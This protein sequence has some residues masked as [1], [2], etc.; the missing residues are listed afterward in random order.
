MSL[1]RQL[2][3]SVL[4]AE[5]QE[6]FEHESLYLRYTRPTTPAP[7][8][9]KPPWV[10]EQER[11][12]AQESTERRLMQ[13]EED[14]MWQLMASEDAWMLSCSA[15]AREIRR[16][17]S[18]IVNDII[19][20]TGLMWNNYAE[21]RRVERENQQ[22]HYN[23]VLSKAEEIRYRIILAREKVYFPPQPRCALR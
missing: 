18:D 19:G 20:P 1:N 3:K 2:Y 15:Q 10:I 7:T 22:M 12:R 21:R 16:T 5:R 6:P 9:E 8:L 23:D 13:R 11:Q 4:A 14:A 17:V